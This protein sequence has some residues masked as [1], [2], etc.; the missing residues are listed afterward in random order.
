M[1]LNFSALYYPLTPIFSLF[2]KTSEINMASPKL[3]LMIS[4]CKDPSAKK[5]S[6]PDNPFPPMQNITLQSGKIFEYRGSRSFYLP[7]TY[8]LE[9]IFQDETGQ[10]NGIEPFTCV[11]IQVMGGTP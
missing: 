3:T 10:W 8:F 2:F 6:A 4:G 7:G 11:D 5:W 1:R 9:P